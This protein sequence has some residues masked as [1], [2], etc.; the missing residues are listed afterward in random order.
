[1]SM[2]TVLYN[3][4]VSGDLSNSQSAPTPLTLSAGTNSIIG[5]VGTGDTADWVTLTIPAGMQL[6]SDVLAAYSSTDAQGFTGFQAG[7]SFV[8][9]PETTASAYLGYA[10]FGTGASNNGAA[11]NLLGHDL[12]PIMANPLTSP[13]AQGFTDPLAAGKYTF[14]I[15]QLG[16]ATNYQFDFGVTAVPEPACLGLL[17]LVLPIRRRKSAR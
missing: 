10:H 8:G 12:L 13:G 11:T 16:A 6:S 14:L 3:E 17:A 4:S 5:S 15:Q 9:N 2:A 1:M 7:S